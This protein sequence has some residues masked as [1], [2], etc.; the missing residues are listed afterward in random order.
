MAH[1]KSRSMVRPPLGQPAE[2]QNAISAEK[3][4]GDLRQLL[5]TALLPQL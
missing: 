1:E 3:E 5:S 2:E 4:G